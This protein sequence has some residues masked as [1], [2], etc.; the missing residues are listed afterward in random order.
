MNQNLPDVSEWVKLIG[1][2][3]AMI[4]IT[5]VAIMLTAWAVIFVVLK[6]FGKNGIV[7]WIVEKF[8]GVDGYVDSV[9]QEHNKFVKSVSQTNTDT[10]EMVKGALALSEVSLA[11]QKNTHDMIVG[12]GHDFCGALDIVANRLEIPEIRHQTEAIRDRLN[13]HRQS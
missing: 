4:V 5:A 13:D 2:N 6:L 9:V 3:G 11:R 12:C 1:D 7:P 10:K 8:M